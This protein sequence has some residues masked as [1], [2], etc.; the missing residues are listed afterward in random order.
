MQGKHPR[1]ALSLLALVP[2]IP[3]AACGS[4]SSGGTAA[5][6]GL[7]GPGKV[8]VV[9]AEEEETVAPPGGLAP[10]ASVFPA[11]SA[12]V[13]DESEVWV[14]DPS[15]ESLGTINSILADTSSTAYARMVNEGPYVAQVVPADDKSSGG[16]DSKGQSSAAQGEEFELFTVESLRA[17][18]SSPQTVK[19]W[20]PGDFDHAPLA[21]IYAQMELREEASATN[22]FG[23]FHLDFAAAESHTDLGTPLMFG[24][25]AT[26]DVAGSDVGFS[27]YSEMGDVDSAVGANEFAD[28]T[29]VNVTMSADQTTGVAKIL[30]QYR[31]W[32]DWAGADSGLQTESW[33]VAF[34]ETHFKRQTD[35]GP[36][37][38]LSRE[39]F[40][41]HVWNY[42]LYHATG[43]NVG[44]LVDRNS[45]FGF[46][47]PGGEHGWVGY[48]G[49]W[50]P[51]GVALTDGMTVTEEVW[52]DEE[53]ADTYTVLMAPGKLIRHT[54][55][56]MDLTELG[57]TTFDFWDW[58]DGEQYLVTYH[59]SLFWR[60][61]V[62]NHG[63]GAWDA[64][65]AEDP[66]DLVELGGWLNMW[67]NTLGG[68]VSYLEGS[69]Y[70]TFYAEEFVSPS[71]DLFLGGDRVALYGYI[72]CLEAELSAADVEAG[73]V[74]L[75]NQSDLLSPH[76]YRFDKTDMTLWHDAA[77]DDSD[78]R[79]VGLAAG[80]VPTSG[81]NLWGMHGGPLVT[82]TAGLVN[83]W[84]LW[85]LP[86][87]YTYETGHN[88][89]N[90]YGAVLDGNGDA[91]VFDPP[92]QFLYEH[93]TAADR[94]DDATYDG[95]CF[96]LD[97]NG[98]GDLW[99]IPHEGVDLNGDSQ[100]D[101][102]YPLFSLADG[103]LVGPTGTEYVVRAME[104]EQTLA[105][106]PGA[107][108]GLDVSAADS[109]VLPTASAYTTP[110]IGAEPVV[111]GP[112]AV[113]D[114]VVQQ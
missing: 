77:G 17:T 102:W 44:D 18:N 94:N 52:D 24:T 7:E 101:R 72:D 70:I 78:P 107:A 29:R 90:Q 80:Q 106:D 99:G 58:T 55:N 13:T 35:S 65:P 32:D 8:S 33:Q 57:S 74:Y 20:V 98:P 91:V 26:N 114:G 111:E 81:P 47:L 67:S 30:R 53:V 14:Y 46:E 66:I 86:E 36:V 105:E 45:G 103:T 28:R 2:L 11:T 3:L 61:A 42:N 109:L 96:Y 10:G 87:F 6:T 63:T 112:P 48:Y 71:D 73:D 60:T 104:M 85:D 21:S 39:D 40:T 9:T 75:A 82:S 110:T 38:T 37:T 41:T 100:E 113:V 97:Y 34:D 56:Q 68:S 31:Y 12:Y 62:M 51:E 69:T 50:V 88:E 108:P 89:W 19:F 83:P 92:L 79:Q 16:D 95:E 76:V 5:I 93:T 4:G 54:K 43:P 84:D 49:F 22:P 64:L 15:M 59:S 23:A 1:P 25:L 27:F